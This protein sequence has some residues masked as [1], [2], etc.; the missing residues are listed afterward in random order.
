MKNKEG[1]TMIIP[2][3]HTRFAIAEEMIDEEQPDNIVFL[4]DYFDSFTDSL[5]ITQQTAYWL[6]NSLKKKNRIH[7][8]GNHDLSYLNSQYTCSGFSEGKLYAIKT[9]NVDLTKLKHYCW[10]DD[11]L[12]TH[13]GLSDLFYSEFANNMTVNDFLKKY[14]MDKD[15]RSLLYM[16]GSCRGGS[17]PHSGILWCDYNYE[18]SDIPKVKQIFGHTNDYNPRMTKNHICLDTGLH[19]YAI[20]QNGKMKAMEFEK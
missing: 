12:C 15:L 3:L 14:S 6:K 19:H 10:V 13:A 9:T 5:E 18:F 4:G 8:L 2:D 17:D 16:C 1:K 7:L 20:Y 11:W